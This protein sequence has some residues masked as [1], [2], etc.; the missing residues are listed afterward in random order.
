MFIIIWLQRDVLCRHH[1]YLDAKNFYSDAVFVFL[2]V[3]SGL[4]AVWF[5]NKKKIKH[6]KQVQGSQI[7]IPST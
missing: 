1:I 5:L 3:Y 7:E 6:T 2:F 4:A